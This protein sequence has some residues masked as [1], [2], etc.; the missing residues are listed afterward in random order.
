MR[1]RFNITGSCI[2]ER[3]YMVRLDNRL[4]KIKEDF[5][6]GPAFVR[7]FSKKLFVEFGNIESGDSPNMQKMLSAFREHNVEAGLDDLFVCLSRMCGKSTRPIV[8]MIDEV[9]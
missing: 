2:P 8:L 4:K 6:D 3:H 9:G 5:I 7:A 1:R